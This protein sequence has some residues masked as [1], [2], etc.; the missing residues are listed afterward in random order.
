M[1]DDIAAVKMWS[2]YILKIGQ[3][4]AQIGTKSKELGLLDLFEGKYNADNVW[5]Y[6][7]VK[8]LFV[9]WG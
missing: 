2:I 9:R 7:Y 3:V 4:E 1:V 6:E 5:G 8:P